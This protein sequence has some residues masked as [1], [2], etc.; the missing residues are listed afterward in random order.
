MER[1]ITGVLLAII[2]LMFS[3]L[4]YWEG[5]EE[6]G[7]LK[8]LLG[9]VLGAFGCFLFAFS[10]EIAFGYGEDYYVFFISLVFFSFAFWLY[11][12]ADSRNDEYMKEKEEN[13][14]R[15]REMNEINQLK[16]DIKRL[17]GR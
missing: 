10:A 8:K 15:N 9:V 5:F 4:A 7:F 13:K 17:K 14:I 2:C 3:K 1:A 11:W 6:D 16:K 12:R